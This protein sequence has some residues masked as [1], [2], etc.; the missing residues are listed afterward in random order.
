MTDFG[1]DLSCV[2]DLDPTGAV[3]SG[4]RLLAEA[5][6]RRLQ[7]PRGGLI[8]DPDYG[9]DVTDF[10]ND[11]L[12]PRD[13][14]LMATNINAECAKDQRILSANSTVTL[15]AGGVLMI[16]VGLTDLDGPFDLV[17]AVSDVTVAILKV[18]P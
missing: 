11:D 1:S 12:S 15:A 17:L 7:T 9:Y 10:L 6:A 16:S 13:L 14:A 3:V 18:S 8:D 4:R 5:I 2:T